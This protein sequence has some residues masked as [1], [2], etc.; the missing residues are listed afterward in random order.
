MASGELVDSLLGGFVLNYVGHRACV[1]KSSLAARRAKMHIELREVDR[2]KELSGVQERNRL[3]RATR[4]G[5][6]I[7]AVPHRIN[8]TELSLEEFWDNLC[9][10][11]GLMPQDIPATWDGCGKNFSI[12]H[13]LSCPK[14]G[15]VLAWHDENA[16]EW[17]T[18]GARDLVPSAII[19][20]QKINSRT[21]QGERTRARARQEGGELVAARKL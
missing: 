1:H 5:A 21:V 14:G 12:E 11:Y 4:N 19:Y 17:F 15:L 16:K 13:N 7:S 18:L 9:L 10:R 6:W 2:R 20:E 3:H 8:G